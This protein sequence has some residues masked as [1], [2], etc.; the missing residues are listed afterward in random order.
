MGRNGIPIM[1]EQ[2]H[3]LIA[4]LI[5]IWRYYSTPPDKREAKEN[6]EQKV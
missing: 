2:I 5:A 3:P 4:E 6:E 1:S